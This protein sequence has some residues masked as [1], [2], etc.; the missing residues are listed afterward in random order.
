MWA[1]FCSLARSHPE[2][3]VDGRQ[4]PARSYLKDG[5]AHAEATVDHR[6][7]CRR[8]ACKSARSPGRLLARR[9]VDAQTAHADQRGAGEQDS[10]HCMGRADDEAG[11]QSSGG[12]RVNRQ[13]P[14]AVGGR[15][16]VEGEY[17]AT[18]GKTGSEEPVFALVRRARLSDLDPVRELPYKPAAKSA[19]T[20]RTDGS[21]R[22]AS[23]LEISA[24]L[25]WGTHRRANDPR[26]RI[27][28]FSGAAIP[29]PGSVGTDAK[30]GVGL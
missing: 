3:K 12:V 21:I 7:Q 19:Q 18:V 1:G 9:D 26:A 20:G 6:C 8:A 15:Q 30:S 23:I 11:L 2:A 24:C 28:G 29:C 4:N 10:T 27:V 14:E 22:S 5:R 13:P 16:S 17:G 25:P